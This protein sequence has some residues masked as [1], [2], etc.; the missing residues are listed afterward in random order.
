M[1]RHVLILGAGGNLGREIARAL[2]QS[3]GYRVTAAS[4]GD[5]DITDR[6]QVSGILTSTEP[7]LV[8]CTAAMTQVDRAEAD[9][10]GAF[11]VNAWGSEMLARACR[12]QG[13]RLVSFSSDFV[14]DGRQADPY[15]EE[16]EPAPLSVY[17]RSKLAGD[18]AVLG[19]H[20]DNMVLRVGNLYGSFGRNLPARLPDLL[21]N[22]PRPRLD[23]ERTMAPTW[24]RDVARQFLVMLEAGVPGGLY[25]VASHGQATWAEFGAR[26]ARRLGLEDPFDPVPSAA[27]GLPAP[28]PA[29]SVLRNR[30]LEW[31]GLDE[32]PAWEHALDAWLDEIA[33]EADSPLNEPDEAES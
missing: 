30:H 26:M 22:G 31:L 1:K 2:S 4:H 33:S 14:F 16:D 12:E 11:L 8:V 19:M 24:S 3:E 27:L 20:P 7:D 28:R 13:V 21:R 32:M 29:Y 15:C 23:D 9:P 5:C 6:D 25:H 10:D 17:G 18:R